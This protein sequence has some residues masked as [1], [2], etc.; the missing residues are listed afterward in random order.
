MSV[1]LNNRLRF[2][3]RANDPTQMWALEQVSSTQC[4]FL[5]VGCASCSVR[6]WFSG[7]S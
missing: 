5:L 6:E 1:K 4:G 7:R 2:S 3:A